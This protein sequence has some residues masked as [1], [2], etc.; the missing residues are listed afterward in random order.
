MSLENREAHFEFGANWRDYA[1][2]VNKARIDLAIEGMRKL[3]PDGIT[4][5]TFLDIGCGSG[6][7]AL[8]ALELGAE[9]VVGIDI[10]E[11]SVATTR[12]LLKQYAPDK[13]WKAEIVSV[14][15]TSAAALGT[16][17]IVYSWGVL[18]HTG[19]MWRAIERAA[20]LVRPGGRFAI[21]IY[22]KTPFDPAWKVEKRLYSSSPPAV[23]WMLRQCFFAALMAGKT[24]RGKNPLAIFRDPLTR[25]MSLSHDVHDWLGGYPYETA[26]ADELNSRI[27]QLGFTE[28]RSFRLPESLGVLGTGCHEFVFLK[29]S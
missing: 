27:S 2:T 25:G 3:F 13:N 4:G 7:H 22:A 10:D 9:S 29:Q 26:S 21:A 14:F 28:L 18:H 24:L 6:L 15:D 20:A 8:A 19:S 17:D 1:R 11:N 23:Q 5:K 16:F 12:E